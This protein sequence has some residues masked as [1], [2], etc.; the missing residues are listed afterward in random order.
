[1]ARLKDILDEKGQFIQNPPLVIQSIEPADDVA[2][3]ILE[4]LRYNYRI[5]NI[6]ALTTGPHGGRLLLLYQYAAD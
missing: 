5:T 1:M 4:H 2:K 3:S 6:T